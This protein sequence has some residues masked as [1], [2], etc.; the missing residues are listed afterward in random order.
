MKVFLL[1][2]KAESHMMKGLKLSQFDQPVWRIAMKEIGCSGWQNDISIQSQQAGLHTEQHG[3]VIIQVPGDQ[4]HAFRNT[5]IDYQDL[6]LG[7]H[8]MVLNNPQ[9]QSPCGCG[10]SFAL[11]G[12]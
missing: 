8:K 1:S 7:Q 4:V 2:P 12:K 6:G 9:A 5:F 10:D 3:S 11:E